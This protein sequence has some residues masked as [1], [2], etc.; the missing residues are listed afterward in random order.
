MVKCDSR[1][2]RVMQIY[3]RLTAACSINNHNYYYLITHLLVTVGAG[4]IIINPM[5]LA[6][7]LELFSSNL[8][9]GTYYPRKVFLLLFHCN[10]GYAN[11]SVLM[12]RYTHMSCVVILLSTATARSTCLS[13]C[14]SSPAMLL[15]AC[16]IVFSQ[17]LC[18]YRHVSLFS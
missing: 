17:S 1:I 5:L 2:I 9:R 7:L 12:F 18:Y 16:W 10:N 4:S 13:V 8:G 11:A 15:I 6:C 3:D 14:V